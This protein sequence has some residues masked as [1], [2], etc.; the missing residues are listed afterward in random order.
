MNAL[1]PVVPARP[2]YLPTG[3]GRDYRSGHQACRRDDNTRLRCAVP[4]W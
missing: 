2:A 1:D 3:P 4:W